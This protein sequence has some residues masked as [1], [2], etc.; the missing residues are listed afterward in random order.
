MG[1]LENGR[2]VSGTAL[3]MR[4][5]RVDLGGGKR[6][7]HAL[8]GVDLELPAGRVTGLVGE[9]GSGKTT[10]MLAAIGLLPPSARVIS[11]TISLGPAQLVGLRERGWREI[12]G[13]RIGTIFQNARRA[14]HPMRTVGDQLVRVHRRHLG[15]SRDAAHDAALEVLVSV[16]FDEPRQI[17]R[18]YPHQLSGGQCQRAMIGLSLLP[19]PELL[20]ADEPTSG[21]DVT[22]QQQV[23]E[24]LLARVRE[25]RTTLLLISHDIG[26]IARTCDVVNVMY[27]GEIVESGPA[28]IV[29]GRP[30]HPY[31]QALLASL[32]AGARRMAF[33][34]GTVPDLRLPIDGC[35]FA[36][37]CPS[38]MD[39]CR[40]DRP[41]ERTVS[42]GHRVRCELYPKDGHDG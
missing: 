4:D 15:S 2:G 3:T 9:S 40:I 20:L 19:H 30:A 11:G 29:L 37:R 14:L 17:A 26:V 1:P 34:P 23:L 16:G 35:P 24:T 12:R 25:S 18:R 22:I 6:P 21:L 31:T 42:A 41:A 33:V 7:V 28:E 10:A 39:I 5:L 13:R 8:R 27:A 36:D 32:D 38:V